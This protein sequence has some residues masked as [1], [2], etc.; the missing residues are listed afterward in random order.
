MKQNYSALATLYDRI[1]SHVEY[2]EWVTYIQKILI[3]FGDATRPS[4]LEIGGGTGLLGRK[5]IDRGMDYHGCDFSEAMCQQAAKRKTP[6]FI[7]DARKLPCK[8]HRFDLAIFLYDGINYLQS[9][10]EYSATFQQVH[11]CL[12]PGGLFLF[13]ITTKANSLK[14]FNEFF[15]SADYDDHFYFRRSYYC[16]GS[17]LQCNDFTIFSKCNESTHERGGDVV[18]VKATEHHAQKVFPAIAI[19]DAVPFDLF[20]VLG[21]WDGFSFKRHSSSSERVHFLLKKKPS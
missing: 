9:I 2:D 11:A 21:L 17:G 7:A 5:L 18:Y 3:A 19:R 13:D 20:K 6:F 16:A 12:R 1:M 15:D 4:L 14:N 10:E 8:A